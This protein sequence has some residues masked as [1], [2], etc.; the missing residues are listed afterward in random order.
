MTNKPGEDPHQA[1]VSVGH[2]LSD[3]EA[4]PLAYA[5][6]ILAVI[7]ILIGIGMAGTFYFFAKEQ[8]LGPPATPFE[9]ARTL[10]PLPRLQ[11]YPR[12]ELKEYRDSQRDILNSY[13]WVDRA[14]G[15][16]RIPVDR[17]I[18]LVLARGLPVRPGGAAPVNDRAAGS[19]V[20]PGPAESNDEATP[21]NASGKP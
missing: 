1:S 3:A 10:P 7:L 21:S 12:M 6:L 15:V 9:N 16:V 5:G 2:E 17:A 14:G 19:G 11:V 20:I 4:R 13:G 18:E 8:K